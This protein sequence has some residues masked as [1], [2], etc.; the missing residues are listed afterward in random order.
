MINGNEHRCILKSDIADSYTIYLKII[1]GWQRQHIKKVFLG[2][3]ENVLG[4]S[5]IT[6]NCFCPVII[7][8]QVIVPWGPFY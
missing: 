4:I 6:M 2:F 1:K 5:D 8:S 7:N 3:Y